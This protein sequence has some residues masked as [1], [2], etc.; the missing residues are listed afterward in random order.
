MRRLFLSPFTAI[1]LCAMSANSVLAAGGAAVSAGPKVPTQVN[2]A[3]SA[4][5]IKANCAREI[6]TDKSRAEA[7]VAE[8]GARTLANTLLPLENIFA[9]LNDNLAGEG[10]LAY[11][12]SDKPVREASFACGSDAGNMQSDFT[13]E[14]AVYKALSS[15]KTSGTARTQ[16]DKKLLEFW[17]VGSERSGAGL[18]PAKRQ[19]FI[20]LSHKLNDLGTAWSDNLGSDASTVSVTKEQAASLPPDLLSNSKATA[21]GGYIVPVNESTATRFFTSEKDPAGRKAFYMVYS[22]RAAATNLPILHQAIAIRDQ[23][24]HLIGEPNWAAYQLENRM[25]QNP[26]RVM[27]FLDDLQMKLLPK[28]RAEIE[29][30]RLLKAQDTGNPRATFDAWDYGYYNEM[31]LRTKYAVDTNEVRQYFPA[32]HTIDA[33]MGIYSKLL[34]ITFAK[35]PP[36]HGLP[37][38]LLGYSVNDKA[39]GQF[40]GTF[41]LDLYPRPGKFSHFANFPFLPT[42]RNADGTMRPPVSM[43]IGN[44]PKAQPGK[45]S[46]LTH[47][48]VETF[49]HE[50]GHN[51]AAIL[52][53]TPYETLAGFRL[54][55]IEAPSQMLEN[56]VWDPAILKELSSNVTTGA[57][58]PDELIRKMIAARYVGYAYTWDRQAMLARIDMVYHTSGPKVDT[59]AVW[60]E[61][62]NKYSPIP[63]PPGVHPEASFGHLFGYDA[64]YYAYAWS[65]VFAQDMFTVFK[66]GG[67]E[68]PLVGMRYRKDIL[69]PAASV[70]PDVLLRNFLGRPTNSDAFFAEFGIRR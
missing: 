9:D 38:E 58:L 42:R 4:A 59:T 14:P 28:A 35:I 24:A 22:N 68:N 20:A 5:D 7:I 41:Y 15:V 55:F 56:W 33:V 40:I 18:S 66:K 6:A 25:A 19:Q 46:L 26:Q 31:L 21:D 52:A 8:A 49:F 57:P 3:L 44:W 34:G 61:I 11:L 64:G 39:S 12:A 67:L 50:F 16:A 30:L 48:D 45:P 32:E 27:A 47:D 2:F 70:E 29:T 37:S 51:M 60:A 17:L 65:R 53:T 62:A 10:M 69:E 1:A 36:P 13:A 63:L 23:L 43:I 54:D